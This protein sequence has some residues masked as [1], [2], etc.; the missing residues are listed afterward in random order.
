M[1]EAT[2]NNSHRLNK[3][4]IR[5]QEISNLK[6]GWHDG[7]GEKI[8]PEAVQA[9]ELFCIKYIDRYPSLRAFPTEEGGILIEFENNIWDL[10][11]EIS[12][13]GASSLYASEIN[14]SKVLEIFDSEKIDYFLLS[15]RQKDD[16][17][18]TVPVAQ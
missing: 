8:A 11:I 13:T 10:S 6:N 15:D 9:A 14:G 5:L 7:S 18:A 1:S 17:A 4:K 2:Q 12:S 3:L 16:A